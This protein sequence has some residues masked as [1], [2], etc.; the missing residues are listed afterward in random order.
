MFGKPLK[1]LEVVLKPSKKQT[2]F[3]AFCTQEMCK[4]DKRIPMGRTHGYKV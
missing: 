4:D 3:T 1:V 2:G